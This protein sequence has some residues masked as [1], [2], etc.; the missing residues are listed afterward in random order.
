MTFWLAIL[1]LSH[2]PTTPFS[3]VGRVFR[4][5]TGAELYFQRL[6]VLGRVEQVT[7]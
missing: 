6:G 2:Q 7:L 4:T 5:S 1:P 3:S